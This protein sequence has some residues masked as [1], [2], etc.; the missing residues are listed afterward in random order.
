MRLFGKGRAAQ[1]LPRGEQ[2]VFAEKLSRL[3]D[4]MKQPEWRS[5]AKL[6]LLGK[7]LGLAALAA[8]IIV[9]P[10]IPDMLLGGSSAM[11]QAP[12][13]PPDPYAAVKPADF[14]NA[15]NTGWVLLGAFLV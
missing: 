3:K 12:T 6:L 8:I 9:G 7:L 13:T 4:R 5:Y 2:L 11:A 15:V 14:I 10:R 1:I